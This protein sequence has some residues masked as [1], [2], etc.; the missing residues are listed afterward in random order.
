MINAL[1][2]CGLAALIFC[3][4][5]SVGDKND[6]DRKE[7]PAPGAIGN[8]DLKACI[9]LLPPETET[10]AVAKKFT[11]SLS[12]EPPPTKRFKLGMQLTV[13]LRPFMMI[14]RGEP[15][16]RL[17][18]QEIEFAI[19]GA[20]SFRSPKGLGFMPY[21]GCHIVSLKKPEAVADLRDWTKESTNEVIKI[22]DF[23]S[24][25]F[26]EKL[27]GDTWTFILVFPSNGIVLC[28]TDKGYLERVLIRYRDQNKADDE[29]SRRLAWLFKEIDL[30]AE[31]WAVRDYSS[32]VGAGNRDP[33]S[34][35]GGIKRQI[36]VDE[37]AM[38]LAFH[39]READSKP[40]ALLKYISENKEALDIAK[41]GFDI[42]HRYWGEIKPAFSG[43]GNVIS[44]S[45]PLG[46]DQRSET[47]LLRLLHL[48]FGHGTYI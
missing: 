12:S 16:K 4:S 19:E 32:L 7:N 48:Y 27:E 20:C 9:K 31:Y 29:L 38:G 43:T 39:I 21:A 44:I 24:Y 45:L 25:V 23:D 2:I 28:A 37:S 47:F 8:K 22:A 15:L 46:K 42:K 34:P 1:N 41:N 26:T 13:L 33:T 18:E 11:V 40:E 30:D 5:C 10:V 35:L 14:K 6:S 17:A 3:L 36:D